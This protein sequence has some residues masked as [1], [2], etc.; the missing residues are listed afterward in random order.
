LEPENV[1]VNLR[2]D[3]LIFDFRLEA[4]GLIGSRRY[5]VPEVVSCKIMGLELT[6]IH[7]YRTMTLD[8]HFE[9]VVVKKNET[10]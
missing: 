10:S 9:K 2:A 4:T 7:S 3:Y 1:E 8:E 6:W 5:M